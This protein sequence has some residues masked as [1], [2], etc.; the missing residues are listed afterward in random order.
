[1]KP[2]AI[3]LEYQLGD[4][5][6]A[7]TG[8]V[9]LVGLEALA[10]LL[11]TQ[12]SLDRARGWKTAGFASGYRGS[13]LGALATMAAHLQGLHA[14]QLYFTGFAQ[15]G[16]SVLRLRARGCAN[17]GKRGRSANGARCARA[18]CRFP[19]SRADLLA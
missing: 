7:E 4:G 12:S 14:S 9:F 17:C 2:P 16:G 1:M 19:S 11:I 6:A 18:R 5:V 3:G 8:R 15:K 13:P 10:R